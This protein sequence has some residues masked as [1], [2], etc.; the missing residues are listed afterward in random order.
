VTDIDDAAPGGEPAGASASWALFV[1]ALLF[2]LFFF[3]DLPLQ[4]DPVRA[5]NDASQFSATRAIE[6]LAKI[7]DGKPHPVDS[8]ALDA[9]RERLIR[10]I[11]ALGYAPEVHDE[12]A[13]RGSI[14]GSA[15]RCARVRNI[16]F[17]AGPSEGPAL[18]LTAHYDSVE[19]SPGFGD[20]GVGVAVWL[21]VAHHLK[22]NPPSRPV[23]FLITD[24]EEVALLGAQA[25]VD[26][27][28]YG[29]AIDRIINL[30]ARGVTG[31]A[32]MFETSH[33]NSGV[34]GDWASGA[35][36]PV[37]NSMMTAIYE[38]LPN[39]TDLTVHLQA[40]QA[41][42]NLA[43]ADGFSFYHTEHDDLE[44]LDPRSV[45]H[46]GDQSLGAV[47]AF[48]A[49]GG[50]RR[51][52]I[53]YSDIASRLFLSLPQMF[54][55]VLLGLCFGLS[56]LLFMRPAK[57]ADW[58]HPDWRALALPPALIVVA[59]LFS[60][61]SAWFTG[62]IRPE[63]AYWTAYPQALNSVFFL[64]GLIAAALGLSF[65]APKSS[66]EALFASGWLW[67]LVIGMGLSFVVPGMSIVFLIPGVVFVI[68][69]AVGWLLPR[70]RV[71]S[72]A[73]AALF[74]ALIF[75][76]MIYLVDVMMTLR[77]AP[78]FGVLE[79]LA[80]AP[81]LGLIG[82]LRIGRRVIFASLGVGYAVA[83]VATLLVP[84][85]SAQRP[86][87]LNFVAHYDTNTREAALFASAPP[88]SL[89]KAV[90]EQLTVD[91]ASVLPGVTARLA[92]RPLEFVERPAASATILQENPLADGSQMIS[93]Q[94]S[95]PG[96]QMVRLRIP[97][98]VFP[99]QLMYQASR[100]A[101]REPQ[102]GYYIVDCNGRSCDGAVMQFQIKPPK[103]APPPAEPPAWIV[104]GYW[105]G[106]P[107][108]AAAVANAR[109]DAALRYQMG[110][111]TITTRRQ[112]F[113]EQK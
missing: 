85:H 94:L 29:Y 14:T 106:L 84:A 48:L 105:L 30:E 93:L 41:G 102:N 60:F 83:L 56:A 112:T 55:L 4:L 63:D 72:H 15:I 58:K 7:L 33:P 22:A 12:T 75:F 78:V 5:G 20:D 103:D 104:Q 40:K 16:T 110:D 19:A 46:M 45:Q 59:G 9:T 24:G 64:G 107:P 101:M 8:E 25:F 11:E 73:V 95:A 47:R 54:G 17:T 31:P 77:L 43:I 49:S 71:I 18:V 79:G 62:L 89:P 61:L 96:A 82:P 99:R 68:A 37:S 38:L 50:G 92:S 97:A 67:F 57:D 1:F 2:A 108:D 23:L 3:R 76:P 111:V 74:L 52:E 26:R 32:M 13:C 27:K 81:M 42:I 109:D 91:D 113:T 80:L 34:V 65:L 88:G 86:L 28:L 98:G 53:V 35:A 39:S 66:R 10:E 36:R 6:R 100:M 51:G 69:A 90:S 70:W 21:E 44:R 87:A